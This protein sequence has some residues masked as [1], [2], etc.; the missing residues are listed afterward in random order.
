MPLFSS[1]IFVLGIAPE[2]VL[3]LGLKGFSLLN[4]YVIS[5]SLELARTI[6]YGNWY[7]ERYK[8][9]TAFVE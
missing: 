5:F 1:C 8:S 6:S 4:W 3:W 2:A 7:N 9:R